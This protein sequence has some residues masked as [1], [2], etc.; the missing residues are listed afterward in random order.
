MDATGMSSL[1]KDADLDPEEDQHLMAGAK[2]STGSL[3]DREV[4]S[5]VGCSR[6]W[7]I[8]TASG[9]P[10]TLPGAAAA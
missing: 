8:A 6:A 5:E 4:T 3:K 9:R 2:A 7:Y 1:A 10:R